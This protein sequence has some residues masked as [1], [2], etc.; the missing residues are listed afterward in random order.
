MFNKELECGICFYPSKFCCWS[1][2]F[3]LKIE[4]KIGGFEDN[5]TT[6]EKSTIQNQIL[7]KKDDIELDK[8]NIKIG[9]DY[10]ISQNG[11]LEKHKNQLILLQDEQ[12]K[13]E[14]EV[15]HE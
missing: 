4:S 5:M 10:L 7:L 6:Q 8:R 14:Q 11:R 2:N 9:E 12:L 13:A 3:L 15:K 1:R